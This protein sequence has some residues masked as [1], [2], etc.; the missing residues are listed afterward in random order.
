LLGL[1]SDFSRLKIAGISDSA[2]ALALRRSCWGT[3][4]GLVS[5][6]F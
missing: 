1:Q 2:N 4:D 5:E 6:A 3:D